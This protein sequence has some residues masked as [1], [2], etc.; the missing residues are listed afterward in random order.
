VD[1]AQAKIS[2]EVDITV[3]NGFQHQ[4]VRTVSDNCQTLNVQ[5]F[6]FE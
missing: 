5:S 3:P 4:I 1:G 2:L 6:G